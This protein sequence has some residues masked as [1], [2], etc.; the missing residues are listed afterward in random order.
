[1]DA[2]PYKLRLFFFGAPRIER[3]GQRVEPDTRKAVALLSY[4]VVTGRPQTRDALAAL[5]YPEHDETHAR[6]A[7][8]RTLSALNKALGEGYLYTSHELISIGGNYPVWVDVLEF[9]RLLDQA[10]KC[11][12]RSIES[13]STCAPW[14][15]QAASLYRADFLAGFSLRDSPGFDEWQFLTGEELRRRYAFALE[16]LARRASLNADHEK[17]IAFARQ[18]VALDPLVEDAQR[19]LMRSYALAGQRNAALRQYQACV[20]ILEKELGVAPLE[21][22]QRLYLDIQR[23][24]LSTPIQGGL[25]PTLD[26]TFASPDQQHALLD[27]NFPLVGRS[28]ETESLL[29]A[30]Q[31]RAGR[32]YFFTLQGEPGIG[33]TR[34]AEEFTSWSHQ[35]GAVVLSARCFEGET[36]LAFAPFVEALAAV[37]RETGGL[38]RLHD[39]PAE[40]VSEAARLL[41]SLRSG[42]DVPV[43]QNVTVYAQ[44]KFFEG[45]RQVLL[46]LAGSQPPGVLFLDDLHWADPASLD[47]LAYIVR[48]LPDQPL[49]VL[50]SWRD[51]D[52]SAQA[53]LRQILAEAQ[54]AGYAT[55]LNLTRLQPADVADLARLVAEHATELPG[56]FTDCLYRESEGLPYFLVEYLD[57][58]LVSK[59]DTIKSEGTRFAVHR[60]W[61]L[62]DRVRDLLRLRISQVDELARQLLAAAAVIGRSFDFV[63]LVAASG[64]SQAETLAGLETLL[65]HR[66]IEECDECEAGESLNY[67][68]THDKLRSLVYEET[69]L[70][71]RRILHQRVADSLVERL[72]YSRQPEQLVSSI[73]NHYHLA[74]LDSQAAEYHRRA[75]EHAQKLYANRQALEQY[76]AALAAGHPDQVRLHELIGDLFT[77]LGE[78][79]QALEHY[80][81][82][83]APAIGA[84]ENARLTQKVGKVYQR[85]GDYLMAVNQ[86]QQAL[87]LLVEVPQSDS[88]IAALGARILA[89]WSLAAYQI[90]EMD[91]ALS[92]AQQALERADTANAARA[93]AQTHNLL[94][95]L[96]RRN[97]QSEVALDHLQE[98]LSLAIRL[99]D[100]SAQV[101]ALNNLALLYS[102]NGQITQAIDYAQSALA[103]CLRVGDRHR[104]AALHNTLA[105]LYHQSDQTEQVIDHLKQ[106]VTIFTEIGGDAGDMQ[107]EVWKLT[108]W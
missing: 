104:A 24:Q 41:P 83:I 3:D 45:L 48:R 103:L 40:W 72:R 91:R 6:A 11:N 96:E 86:Y 64:R 1:M 94:G 39:L 43:D 78:Y 42:V 62:P 77:L 14:L 35:Q 19:E 93:L 17:A 9:T 46:R 53:R 15:E 84:K 32:G 87:Q 95:V 89:D 18:W 76:L 97:G 2:N 67:D 47:F 100:E 79:S 34:L 28:P 65:A 75:G 38:D 70:T 23:N 92:L 69:S 21:E 102:E 88:S 25:A 56:D 29:R 50:A 68:F 55:N 49:F 5:L 8:R 71:R 22:T 33:K 44:S 81:L 20:R 63:T 26:K 80:T 60:D 58:L 7:L 105:D 27:L 54:R 90:G 52:L 85:R 36:N 98:S 73:A 99:Q 74:G 10:Q 31:Q 13:C 108:E 57:A 106:A 4:L 66:L 51:E 30:Y 12:H 16:K 82:A 59:T 37:L 61:D 101:A 107:L